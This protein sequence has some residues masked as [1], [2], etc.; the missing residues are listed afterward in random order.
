M[1][2]LCTI[3]LFLCRLAGRSKE[4]V[5]F[6]FRDITCNVDVNV[7]VIE[8]TISYSQNPRYPIDK[9]KIDLL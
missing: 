8:P 5:E 6:Y 4:K 3:L 7:S 1:I 9:Q 2:I